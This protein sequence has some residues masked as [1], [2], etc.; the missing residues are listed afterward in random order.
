MDMVEKR[1]KMKIKKRNIDM[2]KFES[3]GED[4]KR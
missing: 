1:R 4:E 3:F 2:M